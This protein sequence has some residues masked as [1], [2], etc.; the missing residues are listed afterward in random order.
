MIAG[1]TF[2]CLF[3]SLQFYKTER[4]GR[5]RRR[6]PTENTPPLPPGEGWG[7]G[8]TLRERNS[9]HPQYKLALALPPM[10]GEG[11][12]R[13]CGWLWRTLPP[14]GRQPTYLETCNQPERWKEYFHAVEIP[15]P[16][17]PDGVAK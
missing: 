10:G 4:S 16:K 13:Q 5:L 11:T 6:E 1:S 8:G 3:Y 17:R 15:T 14:G 2:S 9:P 7:E 12:V